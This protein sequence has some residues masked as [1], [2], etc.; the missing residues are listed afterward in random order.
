MKN[1]YLLST[2][3]W[4]YL[5]EIPIIIILAVAIAFNDSSK[6]VLKFYPLIIFLCAAIIFILIYFFRM[7]SISTDEVRA[8]GFFS[9]RDHAFITKG[10][11][12]YLTIRPNH[13]LKVELYGDAG[14]VPAFDWM[15]A[16]D[17][18]HRDICFFRGNAVGGKAAVKRIANYFYLPSDKLENIFEDGFV[19][20]DEKAKFITEQ[21]NENL[22]I[23][24]SFK[25]TII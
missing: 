16:T 22:T 15:K 2:K 5:T 7:I 23:K 1:I 6:D 9:S 19:Y 10:K 21:N 3:L 12:L 20:E 11:T 18:K 24:I 14:E 17:I 8:H 25:I 4:V 13:N